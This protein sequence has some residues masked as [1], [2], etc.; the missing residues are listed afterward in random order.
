MQKF[1]SGGRTMTKCNKKQRYVG[2]MEDFDAVGL[3]NAAYSR[4]PGYVRGKAT[5]ASAM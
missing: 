5:V 1:V 4:M 3:Y 2:K